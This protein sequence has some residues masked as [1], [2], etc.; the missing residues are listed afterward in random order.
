[1]GDEPKPKRVELVRE[2]DGDM[3]ELIVR[4]WYSQDDRLY[5]TFETL[6]TPGQGPHELIEI[7][8]DDESTARIANA[9]NRILSWS[10]QPT[11]MLLWCPACGRRHIDEGVW[12]TK[13][14]ASHAC[15]HCGMV[16]KPCLEPTV[17]VEFLPGTKDKTCAG[18]TF[19][20]RGL[21]VARH[22]SR[23]ELEEHIAEWEAV[24]DRL[25]LTSDENAH[26]PENGDPLSLL[27]DELRKR[28]R[29]P[30]IVQE[31][32]MSVPHEPHH[33]L[34]LFSVFGNEDKSDATSR[35]EAQGWKVLG[36]VQDEDFGLCLIAKP[37]KGGD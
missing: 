19:P 27:R 32:P 7:D 9:L 14:H 8:L 31:H 1:M 11:P 4:A 6:Y 3:S 35:V 30:D 22:L 15:Q 33:A 34:R 16:W 28:I 37:Q 20:A 21:G 36:E 5:C 23:S 29:L 17:G 18:M 2:C 26:R 12:V 24:Y 10:Q 25:G 13:P